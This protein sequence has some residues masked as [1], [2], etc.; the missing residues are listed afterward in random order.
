MIT[1]KRIIALLLA[2]VLLLQPLPI[3]VHADDSGTLTI[4]SAENIRQGDTVPVSINITQ[5]VNASMFQFALAYDADKLELVGANA[6]DLF[7]GMEPP[8]LNGQIVGSVYMN[9]DSRNICSATMISTMLPQES[10]MEAL[11]SGRRS[12]FR[13]LRCNCRRIQ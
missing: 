12:W 10:R 11:Q 5:G 4:S 13:P 9:W 1:T 3:G 8:T 2:A 7:S 6:G